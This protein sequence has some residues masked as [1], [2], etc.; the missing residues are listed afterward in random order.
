MKAPYKIALLLTAGFLANALYAQILVRPDG[1]RVPLDSV[2]IV[3]QTIVFLPLPG[4]TDFE[5]GEI[6]LPINQLQSVEWPLTPEIA[7]AEADLTAGRFAD[8]MRK[9]AEPYSDQLLFR[10][11]PGSTWA[12]IASLRIIAL[13]GA[14]R[15]VEAEK[16]MAELRRTRG[17]GPW[18]GRTGLTI[19][20]KF[21]SG[22]DAVKLRAR[23]DSLRE[24]LLDRSSRAHLALLDGGLLLGEGKAEEAL[25]AYLYVPVFASGDNVLVPQAM[26][27]AVNAHRA[28]GDDTAAG[29]LLTEL[30]L[31]YPQFSA[32]PSAAT[33]VKF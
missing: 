27:G 10:N 28:M 29:A 23:L 15:V 21:S 14:G 26:M 12:R 30:Q 22:T 11:V 1:R 18:A 13:S 17:G 19:L 7:E 8:A 6:P 9:T 3:N 5:H 31:K 33:G 2:K 4:E 25:L 20:E 24:L 32:V 16:L